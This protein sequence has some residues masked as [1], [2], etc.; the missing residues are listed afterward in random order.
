MADCANPRHVAITYSPEDEGDGCP[1]CEA[2]DRLDAAD[3]V[4]LAEVN[5][6]KRQLEARDREIFEMSIELIELRKETCQN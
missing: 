6:L 1:L 3:D 2:M 4:R 5:R